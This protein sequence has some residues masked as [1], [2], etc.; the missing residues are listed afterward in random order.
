[1]R[2][3]FKNNSFLKFFRDFHFGFKGEETIPHDDL[4][5]ILN[6]LKHQLDHQDVWAYLISDNTIT[7]KGS[8]GEYFRFQHLPRRWKFLNLMSEGEIRLSLFHSAI[9]LNYEIRYYTLVYLFVAFIILV[10]IS[11]ASGFYDGLIN[12]FGM[13]VTFGSVCAFLIL[14]CRKD[15]LY[16]I[17]FLNEA[18]MM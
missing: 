1:M 15:F 16:F 14:R 9:K 3:I 11:S 13:G 5:L 8:L 7:W 4:N 17:N 10:S 12:F 2:E 18:K 6:L